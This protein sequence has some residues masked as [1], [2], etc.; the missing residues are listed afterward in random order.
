MVRTFLREFFLFG[1]KQAQACVFAATFL[2]LLF[3]SRNLP[4]FGLA[5][6]DFLFLAAVAVQ[7]VLV[8]TRL[9]SRDEAL[10][11]CAFHLFGLS[12]ELF[13]TQPAIASWSYPEAAFFKIA[14][15]P[16]YSGFMYAAV[17]S[18]M[19]QAWRRLRLEL[20]GYPSY[21]I[22]VPLALLGYLNFFTHHFLPDI[23]WFVIAAVFIVFRRT[24]VRFTPADRPRSMRL[25]LSFALIGIFV[26][27]AEN[28]TTYLGAYVY[29]HQHNGWRVVSV[30][31]FSSW[32][33]LVIV[34]FILVADLKYVREQRRFLPA[35]GQ[36]RAEPV[37]G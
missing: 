5:R 31:L 19:C 27:L 33:L 2:G 4:L 10:V 14:G 8:W 21:W 25:V 29:P 34:S 7:V 1:V 37:A 24:R 23:R 32:F 9:E 18:Y 3:L 12:L 30:S 20:D 35:K 16:L 36:P 11:L 6:Y 22:S 17:A 26:W 15:V 28:I 13:K